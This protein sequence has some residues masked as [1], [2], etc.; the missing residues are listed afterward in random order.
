MQIGHLLS[1]S[2]STVS[3]PVA[4]LLVRV[5]AFSLDNECSFDGQMLFMI[6]ILVIA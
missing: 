2:N 1:P 3:C 4:E 6:N 5:V